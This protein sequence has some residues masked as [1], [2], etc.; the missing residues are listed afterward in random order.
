MKWYSED[1]KKMLN[2]SSVDGFA[3]NTVEEDYKN[4][5]ADD[6]LREEL[7]KNGNRLEVIISGTTFVLWG[8]IADE[9]YTLLTNSE[10][11]SKKQLL[12]G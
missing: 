6:K 4:P 2:L 1:K 11:E 3:Y 12:K 8:E 5:N 9:V 10:E 7:I